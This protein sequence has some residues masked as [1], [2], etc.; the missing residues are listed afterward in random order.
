MRK[1]PPAIARSSTGLL[2]AADPPPLHTVHTHQP[3]RG[4]VTVHAML[5]VPRV[6]VRDRVEPPLASGS[7]LV[8]VCPA[9]APCTQRGP[10]HDKTEDALYSRTSNADKGNVGGKLRWVG[11]RGSGCVGQKP[12][13]RNEDS[14]QEFKTCQADTRP[15][16]A[17]RPPPSPTSTR[18]LLD[19]IKHKVHCLVCSAGHAGSGKSAPAAGVATSTATTTSTIHWHWHMGSTG[20]R[21]QGCKSTNT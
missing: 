8:T 9:T 2:H 11:G 18:P 20:S 1:N 15:V 19:T 4:F 10:A 3:P 13:P 6:H 7:A 12:L 21:C 16:F 17:N 14:L 5:V